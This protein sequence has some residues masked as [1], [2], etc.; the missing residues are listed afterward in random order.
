MYYKQK[1]VV[2][3]SAKMDSK[4]SRLAMKTSTRDVSTCCMYMYE[5]VVW[6]Q[7]LSMVPWQH[8]QST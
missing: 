7:A 3:G 4:Q 8:K 5:E 2:M 1:G 6:A